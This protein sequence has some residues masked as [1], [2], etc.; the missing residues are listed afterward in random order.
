MAGLGWIGRQSLLVTR[1]FGTF[2]L[3]CELVI[4]CEVD[5]Y[6]EPLP[7]QDR[8]GACRRCVELCPAQ[9][10][11]ENR[12]IDARRCIACRTIECDDAGEEPLSGWI[13]GCD[14]CQS[15]C[16][17][18]K[19]TPLAALD[20]LKPIFEPP[21]ADEWQQMSESQFEERTQDTP[22]RRSSLERVQRYAL[23][24]KRG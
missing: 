21:T 13:F 2:V 1:E 5:Y 7:E 6:D 18:N 20:D 9:A 8:C 4:D 11:N 14:V 22:F 19:C 17:H 3:L 15:C 16:P 12:T 24:N 23:I 10:I